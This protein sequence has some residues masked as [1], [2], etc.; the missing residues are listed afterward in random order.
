M[1]I[2]SDNAASFRSLARQLREQTAEAEKH[3]KTSA[4]WLV[5]HH[6]TAHALWLEERAQ[7]HQECHD[8]LMDEDEDVET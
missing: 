4:D 1:S 3:A 6:L 2:W 5:Y 8:T 7:I